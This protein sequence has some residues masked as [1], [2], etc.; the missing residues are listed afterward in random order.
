MWRKIKSQNKWIAEGGITEEL[1]ESGE[2]VILYNEAEDKV[3]LGYLWRGDNP[4]DHNPKGRFFFWCPTD[5]LYTPVYWNP[6]HWM[7]W[8]QRPE[9]V[10]K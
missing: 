3:V 4:K 8:P 9:E 6:T 1:P 5:E 7:P 10:E 2:M